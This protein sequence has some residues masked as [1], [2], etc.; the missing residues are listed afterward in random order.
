MK[1]ANAV[2]AEIDLAARS[3]RGKRRSGPGSEELGRLDTKQAAAEAVLAEARAAQEGSGVRSRRAARR[4]RPNGH[5]VRRAKQRPVGST[6]RSAPAM[7]GC[8]TPGRPMRWCRSSGFSCSVCFTA[9]PISRGHIKDRRCS[10]GAKCA[11]RSSSCPRRSKDGMIQVRSRPAHAAAPGALGRGAAADA[12]L[13]A[14]LASATNLPR[15]WRRCWCSGLTTVDAA[16][17]SSALARPAD[18][19]LRL[20]D[21]DRAVDAIVAAVRENTVI[22]VNGDYGVDGQCSTASWCH[23]SRRRGKAAR[24][25]FPAACGTDTTSVPRPRLGRGRGSPLIITWT[26]DQC[27]ETVRD[28]EE[29]RIG[30]SFT[31]HHLPGSAL[32]PAT[33]VV[34]P[35]RRRRHVR[36]GMLAGRHRLDDGARD[37]PRLGLPEHFP[38]HLLDLVALATVADVVRWWSRPDHRRHGLG[39]MARHALGPPPRAAPHAEVPARN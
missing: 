38:L 13:V 3:W 26:A 10:T 31:D 35:P 5:G 7:T 6:V 18:E 15:R 1:E 34:N 33:A 8:T 17:T 29:R 32:P 2:T 14:A 11:A 28:A 20:K 27:A 24:R 23:P 16:R 19:P 25:S 21:M 36:P 37:S 12:D 39:L 9:V 22:A 4:C 30:S